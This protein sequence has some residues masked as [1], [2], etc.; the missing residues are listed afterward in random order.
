MILGPSRMFCFGQN[1]RPKIGESVLF[2]EVICKCC[3]KLNYKYAI[4][5]CGD[6]SIHD[7]SMNLL[8]N[9]QYDP[10][11]FRPELGVLSDDWGKRLNESPVGVL[12]VV[13][14]KRPGSIYSHT[15][16]P[17]TRGPDRIAQYRVPLS[18]DINHP[19]FRDW[20]TREGEH[21]IDDC[22]YRNV[23][24]LVLEFC[25]WIDDHSID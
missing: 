16:P 25:D 15:L 1:L 21:L 10:W 6:E 4:I 23:A 19:E 11:S 8:Y 12:K 13:E 22:R 5:S 2:G 7:L 18:G 24:R 20:C 17:L 3:C 14:R 9:P